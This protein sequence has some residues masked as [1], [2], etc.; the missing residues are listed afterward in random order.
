MLNRMEEK[1]YVILQGTNRNKLNE[2]PK[3]N[4]MFVC[5]MHRGHIRLYQHLHFWAK[6]HCRLANHEVELKFFSLKFIVLASAK[7]DV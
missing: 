3:T 2:K 4:P 7:F 6:Y 5:T 1:S